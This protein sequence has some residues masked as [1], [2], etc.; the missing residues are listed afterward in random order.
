MLISQTSF[1]YSHTNKFLIILDSVKVIP[2]PL[3]VAGLKIDLTA[4]PIRSDQ[5]HRRSERGY[6]T[7]TGIKERDNHRPI[8]HRSTLVRS[9]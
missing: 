6:S 7:V 1:I 4:I 2:D 8:P 3:H 9:R 5:V